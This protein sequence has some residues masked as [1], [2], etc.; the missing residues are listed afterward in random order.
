[1]QT[2]VNFLFK[3]LAVLFG[4]F[5]AMQLIKAL[6]G[7]YMVATNVSKFSGGDEEILGKLIGQTILVPVIWAG[8][9]FLLAR[10]MWGWGGG[11]KGKLSLFD[12]VKLTF[13]LLTKKL[14]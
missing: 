12:R 1:M 3:S 8:L 11:V 7:I 10:I 2:I 6:I 13:E 9:L 4:A 14:S 5:F